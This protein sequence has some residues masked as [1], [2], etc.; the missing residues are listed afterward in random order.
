MSRPAHRL[1]SRAQGRLAGR[2]HADSRRRIAARGKDLRGGGV[3]QRLRQD[4]FRHAHPARRISRAGRSR[5]VGDD[6]A[7]MQTGADGRLYAINPETG[8]FGVVPGHEFQI[9]S[10]RDAID[11]A[12]HDLHQRRADRDGDVWW[13]GKDGPPP[14][15]ALDWRGNEWT[16]DS[17][18]KAAHPNSR[19]TTPMRNNPVLAPERRERRGRADQRD[20]FRRPPQRHHA[21][22]LSGVQLESRRLCRRDHGFGNDRGRRPA[23]S[24]R[25][26]AIP[27][28]MLPF[29]GYNMGDYFRHWLKIGKRLK[30]PPAHFPRELVPQRR[31]REISLAR[32]RREH[33]RAQVDRR[34]LRR[35][36][37]RRGIAHR[38][39]ATRTKISMLEGL[40]DVSTE[41]L[42]R[43]SFREPGRVEKRSSRRSR[44]FS[45]LSQPD[46]PPELL[47]QRDKAGVE[48]REY[49]CSQFFS[50]AASRLLRMLTTSRIISGGSEEDRR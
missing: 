23:P 33:A 3:S 29:C 15:H 24:A 10:E 4:E 16:P 9:E 18:E 27:M 41:T 42:K 31:R 17:K 20:H 12:R 22:R 32:L 36:G 44:N 40:K 7:W 43:D 25:C 21:A 13:E 8:Y 39:G 6:I 48:V 37:R 46:M 26:G 49:S 35:P 2:A 50:A 45:T 38:L 11:P 30:N 28:A 19:F 34:P 1:L 5:T 47:A 14:A